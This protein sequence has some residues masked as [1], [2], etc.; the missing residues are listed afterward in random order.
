MIA[1]AL[2]F[3]GATQVESVHMGLAR[4]AGFV[5]A[6]AGFWRIGRYVG[7]YDEHEIVEHR[8]D[9][10]SNLE[11]LGLGVAGGLVPCWDAVGL[12][13][14]AAALGRL[15][16]GVALVLAFSA[17]MA[18]VLVAVGWLAW[19]F[20]ARVFGS[21]GASKWQRGLGLACGCDSLGDRALSLLARVRR[22]RP[23]CLGRGAPGD[24]P[25]PEPS[26]PRTK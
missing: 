16:E 14:L 12:V 5:I 18:F 24:P 20:K 15:G 7:G 2:W 17:G 8:T 6:A 22:P 21:N 19:K 10:M 23:I 9:G 3:T 4:S 11:V 13:V 25:G 1:L 26:R